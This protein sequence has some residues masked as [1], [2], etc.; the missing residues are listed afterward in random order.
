MADITHGT[1]IKDGKAVDKVF[2]K[3]KQVYG[4]NLLLNSDRQF[5]NSTVGQE[6]V[7][8]TFN[9]NYIFDK[10]GTDQVYTISYDLSSKDPSK[11]SWIQ[12]YPFP[13][14]TPQNKYSFPVV[15]YQGITTIPQRFSMTFKPTLVDKTIT[16]TILVFYG[17]YDSGNI[18]IVNRIKVTL[19]N[20]G[21]IAWSPAPED[22]LN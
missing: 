6:F 21:N 2:S 22:I 16:Q 17:Q 7:A 19:G 15:I 14:T 12:A 18:P 10:Y 9:L 1:W 11:A 13:G 3:G 4:R 5:T 20:K 8:T